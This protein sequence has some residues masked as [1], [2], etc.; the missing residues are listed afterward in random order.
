MRTQSALYPNLYVVLVARAGVG[1]T[2]AIF[3]AN[4]F[5]R[6]IESVHHGYTSMTMAN[7][8]DK[9]LESKCRIQRLAKGEA[10]L[11][12]NSM[13][14]VADELSAF[15]S[16]YDSG[17]IAGLTT[18]YDCVP[19]SQGRRT[20]DIRIEIPNPQLNLLCGSTPSNLVRCLPEFAWEQGFTSRVLLV[21]ANDNP[22]IDIF[23]TPARDLPKDMVA[24]LEAINMI[25]GQFGWDETYST[26]MTNWRETGL[27]PVPDHPKLEHYCQRRFAHLMKLTMIANIDRDGHM[28]LTKDDFNIAINWLLEAEHYMRFIFESSSISQDTGAMEEIKHFVSGFPNG[29]PEPRLIGFARKRVPALYVLKTL[30]VMIMSGMIAV[31]AQDEVTSLRTF[32]A[33]AD[34]RALPSPGFMPKQLN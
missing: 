20:N 28:T 12:Y 9:L 7:M 18:F 13:Y 17:I 10:M 8:T 15:M 32:V 25:E 6:K 1:K 27:K 3:S 21:Y 14:H 24:D 31:S 26:A 16:E 19:Y 22:M 4:E 5:V 34:P 11:E 29:C 2:R 30:D 23:N 33:V